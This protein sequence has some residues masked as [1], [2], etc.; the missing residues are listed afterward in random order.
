MEET[1]ELS[2]QPTA[3]GYLRVVFT[4]T[5]DRWS[6]H[7]EHVAPGDDSAILLSSREGTPEDVWPTSAPM[8]DLSQQDLGGGLGKA[9]LG[10]GQA[11]CGHWSLSCTIENETAIKFDWACLVKSESELSELKAQLL[12]TTYTNS[13]RG[14][15]SISLFSV[16]PLSKQGSTS[17][18]AWS[19]K[20]DIVTLE[21]NEGSETPNFSLLQ[22]GVLSKSPTIATRWAY[23]VKCG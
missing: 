3:A 23:L 16:E 6:H 5:S 17:S 20:M 7:I 12:G 4:R 8:Q 13:D 2:T 21:T 1:L 18:L 11:G 19:T 14:E 22:P 10:V 9:I 15:E